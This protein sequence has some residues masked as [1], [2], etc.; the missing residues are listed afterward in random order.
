[1]NVMD[2]H[3]STSECVQQEQSKKCTWVT[4][5]SVVGEKVAA[6]WVSSICFHTMVAEFF[7]HPRGGKQR[8]RRPSGQPRQ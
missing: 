8:Q 2:L 7:P 6:T 5:D 3:E 1:M 4:P